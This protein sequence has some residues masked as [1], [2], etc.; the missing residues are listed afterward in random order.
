M[1]VS[2]FSYGFTDSKILFEKCA[3]IASLRFHPEPRPQLAYD[4]FFNYPPSDYMM[5]PME[6]LTE[7]EKRAI[8][9]RIKIMK[10]MNEE[11]SNKFW[12]TIKT[13]TRF[14]K[15]KTVGMIEKVMQMMSSFEVWVTHGT[16]K[17]NNTTSV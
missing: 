14:V 15:E 16:W 13:G 17:I 12:A 2:E 1:N 4:A 9:L 8:K 5:I 11:Y 3:R 7:K 6:E 10:Q